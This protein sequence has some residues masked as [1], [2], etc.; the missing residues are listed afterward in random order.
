MDALID[1]LADYVPAPTAPVGTGTKDAWQDFRT[2][3]GFPF[4][5]DFQSLIDRYGAG[6]FFTEIG[7]RSPF[8]PNHDFESWHQK[9]LTYSQPTQWPI[10][11]TGLQSGLLCIGGDCNAGS[12][13]LLLQDGDASQFV[14]T[15]RE[16]DEIH[17]HSNGI[18][19]YL[20]AVA[21]HR[22]C[23]PSYE[24]TTPVS[25][26]RTFQPEKPPPS[27]EQLAAVFG[28]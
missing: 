7:I 5:Q 11:E 19:S 25:W 3:F 28:D 9:N 18:V 21:R 1:M 14:Y 12:L 23:P 4:P 22:Q 8:S 27:R 13:Y 17:V 2:S 15:N 16:F 26:P 6:S 24:L 10:F 20:I